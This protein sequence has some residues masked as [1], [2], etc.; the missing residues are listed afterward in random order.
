MADSIPPLMRKK[1]S[2]VRAPVQNLRS[3]ISMSLVRSW[4]LSASVRAITS[5][6]TPITSAANRAATNFCTASVLEMNAGGARFDHSLHQFKRVES[7]AEASFRIG[8]QRR[9]PGLRGSN[10]SF[11]VMDLIGAL[12]RAVD[13]A[14]QVRNAVRRIQA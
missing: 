11:C 12:E 6:G 14:A 1:P 10:F 9:K 8:H 7:S 4:A 2:D 5:V 3:R 13:A